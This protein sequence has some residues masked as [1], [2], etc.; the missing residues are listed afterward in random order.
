MTLYALDAETGDARWQA[1]VPKPATLSPPAV[2]PDHVIVPSFGERRGRLTAVDRADGGEAWSLPSDAGH[3][4]HP[5]VADGTVYV[6][7]DGLV[8]IDASSGDIRWR[9]GDAGSTTRP[10]I[11]DDRLYTTSGH[12]IA[13]LELSK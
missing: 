7:S 10:V 11:D 3:Y 2:G 5:V 6:K 8:A 1:D 9:F 13:A 12:G 4:S